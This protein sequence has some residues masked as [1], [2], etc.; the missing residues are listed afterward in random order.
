MKVNIIFLKIIF[1]LKVFED[2]S[3]RGS[4]GIE[5]TNKHFA[6]YNCKAMMDINSLIIGIVVN[7]GK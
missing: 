5:N 2:G 6:R 7:S 1:Q 4:I 3:D